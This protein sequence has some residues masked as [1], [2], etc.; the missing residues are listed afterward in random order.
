MDTI[1]ILLAAIVAINILGNTAIIH[2]LRSDKSDF[3]KVET[4]QLIS[5]LIWGISLIIISGITIWKS[6]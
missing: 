6:I 3:I 5:E 2:I 1:K 4:V